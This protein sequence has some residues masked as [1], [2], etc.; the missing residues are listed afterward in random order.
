MHWGLPKQT[1]KDV[2]QVVAGNA[3][4]LDQQ[5]F[6]ACLYLMDLAKQGKQVPN[7]LPQGSFPPGYN[8]GASSQ[9]L[10]PS[11]ASSAVDLSSM[12]Q[13][14]KHFLIFFG[15]LCLFSGFINFMIW[16]L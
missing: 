10:A 6:V 3:S 9:N 13:V 12:Q 16:F 4:S 14:G 7:Q 5:R 2:W 11:N 15:F 1:L 8:T